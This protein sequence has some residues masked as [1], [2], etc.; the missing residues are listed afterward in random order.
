MRTLVSL[1]GILLCAWLNNACHSSAKANTPATPPAGEA[2]LPAQQA[3]QAGITFAPVGYE[4]LGKTI[5]AAGRVTFDDRRVAHVFSPVTGRVIRFMAELGQRVTKGDPLAVIASPDLGSASSDLLKAQADLVQSR[6]E[7]ERQ[8]EL[9]EAHAGSQRDFE[10]AQSAYLKAKAELERAEQKNRLLYQGSGTQVTQDYLLPAPINGEV[11]ARSVNP[12]FE[13]QGQYSGGSAPEL[14]TIGELDQVWVLA[15]VFEMDLPRV[16]TGAKATVRVV[17]FPDRSFTGKVDWISGAIDP[18]TRT[19]KVRVVI[20]NEDR[21][22]RPE[23]Y[24]SVNIAVP[25]HKALAVPR[26]AVLR[27][28]DQTVVLVHTGA[29]PD[30][31]LK[32]ERRPVQV[33]AEGSD[34]SLEILHGL[35][36]GDE[37]V[38]SGAILVLGM[39]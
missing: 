21:A 4:E 13:V 9:Y 38:T 36:E 11:I 24:A 18:A 7:Y 16:Q 26:T 23:M 35:Q 29:T 20:D 30:G 17:S 10:A 37:V 6:R 19:A 34:G 8:G 32:I 14:Y 27:Q 5:A 33:D 25:G 31:S 1:C 2:W 12:G 28:G 15:D 3:K 22:L 39:L